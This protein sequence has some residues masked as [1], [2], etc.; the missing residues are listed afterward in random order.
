MNSELLK[1]HP[2]RHPMLP[3][4]SLEEALPLLETEEGRARYADWIN[5]HKRRVM[6]AEND[7][8]GDPFRNG[9]ELPHWVDAD[10]QLKTMERG[11][12]CFGGKRATKSER[13]AKR[14]VQ[15]AWH[16]ARSRIWCMQG[17]LKTSIA[18][19]QSLI[20]KY[21]PREFKALN[22]KA[23]HA[24]SK[25][26]YSQDMGFASN[27][28]VFP[29]RS[30]IHF[31]T[32]NQDPS[33]YTGWKL[34]AQPTAEN[35]AALERYPWLINIGAWCDENLPLL[36]FE[37]M[38]MR[39][40]TWASKWVWTFST[41]DG[42]TQT[43]K[44]TAGVPRTIQSRPAEL[45]PA[46]RKHVSDCPEGHMPY[47]AES[48]NRGIGI[49]Y[50]HTAFN[51]FPPNYEQV[52][53]RLEGKPERAI[54][55]DAY[56]YAEDVQQRAFPKFSAWNVINEEDLPA[57]GTNYMLVDPAS[58]RMYFAI[59]VRVAPG[60]P[61]RYYIY[62][63]HP[64]MPQWGPW[65]VASKRQEDLDGVAGP[66]QVSQ[67]WGWAQYK[68]TWLAKEKIVVPTAMRA[69]PP[70]MIGS[71]ELDAACAREKDPFRRRILRQ[72]ILKGEDLDKV[73]EPIQI[74]FLDSRAAVNPQKTSQGTTTPIAEFAKIDIHPTTGAVLAP[75]MAFAQTS[76]V[77]EITGY[78]CVNDLLNWD[79]DK[80]F[81]QDMNEPRLYVSKNCE[82]V[83]TALSTYTAT[84]GEKGGWKDPCDLVRYMA[85]TT[86]ILHVKGGTVK[87]RGGGSH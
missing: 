9:W 22:G 75:S 57:E 7:E 82:Q 69:L 14:V 2:E 79:M 16:L 43:M 84:G 80:P 4:M 3:W 28:I 31:L 10:A 19:Q 76:G 36:W 63:D 12:C 68:N 48:S 39:C 86:G 60:N 35:R 45:L 5:K 53:L 64:D 17:S 83:I 59:W 70:D 62:R 71:T 8:T 29:N 78:T 21:L 37:N 27:V 81:C 87:T 41:M 61:S 73:T 13:A 32:Y 44:A 85:T 65:A 54:K 15:A 11:H 74:R 51:P 47:I 38:E 1:L 46:T 49:I 55:Q 56:G 6:L 23:R 18:E 24:W 50:F 30:E 72:A 77:D 26:N 20:W 40:S 25:L 33:E 67:G 58:A 34:G 42:M 66:A 52:K